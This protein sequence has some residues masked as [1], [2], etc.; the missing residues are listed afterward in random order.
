MADRGRVYASKYASI[1][2]ASYTGSMYVMNPSTGRYHAR[3]GSGRVIVDVG[4]HRQD[5]PYEDNYGYVAANVRGKLTSAMRSTIASSAARPPRS[6]STTSTCI[7][8]LL[9]SKAST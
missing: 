8:C 6:P 4:T 3:P 5:Y 1:V 9:R 7:C 2:H